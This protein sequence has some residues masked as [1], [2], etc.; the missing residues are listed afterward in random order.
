M[1]PF[2][3]TDT[4]EERDAHAYPVLLDAWEEYRRWTS[5]EHFS[6]AFSLLAG[7]RP[8]L[9]DIDHLILSV[10]DASFERDANIGAD[11]GFFVSAA[12]Q[13]VPETVIHYSLH[14]P[15]LHYLGFGLCGKQLVIDG[16][17]GNY[18]GKQLI[19]HLTINGDTGA[20]PGLLM[21]GVLD[22]PDEKRVS[23]GVVDLYFIGKYHGTWNIPEDLRE[24]FSQD[25]LFCP[26]N[27]EDR[28]A[29]VISLR[30][31]YDGYR[32]SVWVLP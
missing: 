18:V 10:H 20:N 32:L 6:Q 25:I 22:A 17:V 11:L 15:Y 31:R 16:A 19:G 9:S 8:S 27:Y 30:E 28:N 1:K 23:D 5:D 3:H 12:Y 13:L 29:H 4:R 21:L 2:G 26:S 14:T 24:R 7:I